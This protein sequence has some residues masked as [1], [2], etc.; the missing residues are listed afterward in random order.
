MPVDMRFDLEDQPAATLDQQQHACE[1]WRIEFNTQRPHESLE[2][3]TPAEVYRKSDLKLIAQAV[4]GYPEGCAMRRVCNGSIE[5]LTTRIWVSKSIEGYQVGLLLNEDQT[6]HVYFYHH[7]IGQ[8]TIGEGVHV[9]PIEGDSPSISK[10]K[11][12]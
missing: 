9:L 5:F 11:A 2:M 10:Q 7:L 3:K 4:G 12:A 6:Y 1:K 8:I